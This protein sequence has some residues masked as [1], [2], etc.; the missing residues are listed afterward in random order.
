MT[1]SAKVAVFSL[2]GGAATLAAELIAVSQGVAIPPSDIIGGGVTGGVIVGAVAW[3]TYKQKV[4]ALE[5]RADQL[6]KQ[7]A[8]AKDLAPIHEALER[9]ES[10][11]TWLARN[12]GHNP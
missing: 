11:V 6:E 8:D 4:D 7:K 5:R 10:N 12:R 1:I 3:A 2:A 9:I